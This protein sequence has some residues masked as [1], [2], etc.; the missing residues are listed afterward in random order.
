MKYL[1]VAGKLFGGLTPGMDVELVVDGANMGADGAHGDGELV[2]DFLV[3]VAFGEQFEDFELATGQ[4]LQFR[5]GLGVAM[6]VVDDLARNL[7]G[8]GR[9][10]VVNLLHGLDE[11]GL[12][13]VFEQI[14][15]GA[16]AQGVE[17]HVALIVGREHED[18]GFGQGFLEARD[19]LDA[20][21][22]GEVDIHQDHIGVFL[23]NFFQGFFARGVGA[24]TAQPGG[25][26][27]PGHQALAHFGLIFD[28]RNFN[29][30]PAICWGYIK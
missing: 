3:H 7:Q 21:H 26:A 2:G 12:R 13:H 19:A 14:T 27:E 17:N 28:Y 22:A 1:D 16:G 15:V 20:V 11:L 6:E 29:T 23:R 18:L 30:H 25:V 10:T 4:L 24:D 9:A 8:H 5:V